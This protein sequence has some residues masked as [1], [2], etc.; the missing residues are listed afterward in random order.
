V[1]RQRAR[2]H[3]ARTALYVANTGNDTV[4]KIAVNNGKS[5]NPTAGPV[6]VFVNS[7][8][9]ADGVIVDDD[10]I[11]WVCANHAYE[12]V[13]IEPTQGRVI[14]KLGDFDGTGRARP[15]NGFP[16]RPSL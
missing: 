11:I 8:N 9:G 14:A 12:L 1:R 15:P 2:L 4:V 13:V 16:V 7:I 6:I 3:Q 10:D 5:D